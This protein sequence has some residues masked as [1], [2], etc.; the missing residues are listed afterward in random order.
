MKPGAIP[1]Q[2]VK[3]HAD[4]HIQQIFNGNSIKDSSDLA[5]LYDETAKLGFSS[6]VRIDGKPVVEESDDENTVDLDAA[7]NLYSFEIDTS[8]AS[9]RRGGDD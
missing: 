9:S 8:S 3:M 1:L 6:A 4:E 2:F 5:A 7:E